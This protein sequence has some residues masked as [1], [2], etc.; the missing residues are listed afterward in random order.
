MT[1][2]KTVQQ[3]FKGGKVKGTHMMQMHSIF[4]DAIESQ[5]SAA[6]GIQLEWNMK[7]PIP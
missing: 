2:C 5:S 4:M 6:H 7:V 3:R 1:E